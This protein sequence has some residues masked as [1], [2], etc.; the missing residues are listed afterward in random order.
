MIV[1]FKYGCILAFFWKVVGK[2]L[3][4]INRIFLDW[5]LVFIFLKSDLSVIDNSVSVGE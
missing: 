4:L 2:K 1:I 5:V 3:N